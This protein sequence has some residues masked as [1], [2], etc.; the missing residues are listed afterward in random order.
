ME[1]KGLKATT[2]LESFEH[3]QTFGLHLKVCDGIV[4]M[5]MVGIMAMEMEI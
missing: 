2:T 3:L 4:V 5:A 1:D